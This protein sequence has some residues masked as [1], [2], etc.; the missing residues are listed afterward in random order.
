MSTT[1]YV[2]ISALCGIGILTAVALVIGSFIGMIARWKSAKRRGH[3][4]RLLLAMLVIPCL[5]GT[6][7]IILW[8]V[9]LPELGRQ[10]D[11][12]VL[13]DHAPEVGETSLVRVGD[14]APNFS[15][16]TADGDEFVLAEARGKVVLIN[17]FGTSCAPCQFELPHIDQ[18]WSERKQS[19]RFE[20]L[21]IGD[22]ESLESVREFRAKHGFTFPVAAD[23][24]HSVFS[25]F[26]TGAIPQTYILSDDG[27]CVYNQTGYSDEV[28]D[29]VN[30][31]LDNH[32]AKTR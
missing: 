30:A 1:T 6:Q 24:D 17:F 25:L 21:V 3:V 12:R 5:Y 8:Q 31:I 4:I 10:H 19:N 28:I 18:I 27:L 20:L 14:F 9:Y 26:A 32:L 2:A 16:T 7:R 23:P 22:G 15:L 13:A 29:R 11:A